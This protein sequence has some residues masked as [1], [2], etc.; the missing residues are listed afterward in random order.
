[1]QLS[2]LSQLQTA[3]L[4]Q[5]SGLQAKVLDFGFFP[6]TSVFSRNS[7]QI[8]RVEE[9]SDAFHVSLGA[10]EVMVAYLLEVSRA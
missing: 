1:M 6:F 4:L 2:I 8:D 7:P 10:A 3:Q 5:S 9:A